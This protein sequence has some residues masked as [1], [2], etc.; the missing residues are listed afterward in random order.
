MRGR[1]SP[2]ARG[3]ARALLAVA[4]CSALLGTRPATAQSVVPCTSASWIYVAGF[5]SPFASL[6]GY[7]APYYNA[8]LA[9]ANLPKCT[10]VGYGLSGTA[11]AWAGAFNN[12]WQSVGHP[13]GYYNVAGSLS[14]ASNTFWVR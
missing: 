9:P 13:V 12:T 14:N 1:S 10:N 3:T 8:T 7:Y 11:G 2:A 4:A 6:N 5:T